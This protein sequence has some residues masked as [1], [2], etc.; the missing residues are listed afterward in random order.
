[1]EIPSGLRVEYIDGILDGMRYTEDFNW[2]GHVF[3]GPLTQI[4]R[5]LK[6]PEARRTGVY[7]LFGE[8]NC[9]KTVYVGRTGEKISS[10][11]RDH[12]KKDWWEDMQEVILVTTTNL[13]LDPTYVKYLEASLFSSMK[14]GSGVNLVN[15]QEPSFPRGIKESSV[16]DMKV[17]LNK[18]RR[19]IKPLNVNLFSNKKTYRGK[20]DANSSGSVSPTLKLVSKQSNRYKARAFQKGQKFVVKKGSLARGK[21]EGSKKHGKPAQSM[22]DK[23][24]KEKILILE[25]ENLRFT[26]NF[27]FKSPS[28]AAGVIV[29]RHAGPVE[30]RMEEKSSQTLKDRNVRK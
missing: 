4:D 21:W 13:S 2:V 7:I 3:V 29:G 17:F 30:W 8:R 18:F 10:R 1:M 6:R 19:N 22:R 5:V 12:K 26:K 28:I 24:V 16:Q 25:G 14:S 9:K 20:K 11:L 27:E 15:D 23:L